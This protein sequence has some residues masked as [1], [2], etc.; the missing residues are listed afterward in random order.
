MNKGEYIPGLD[1]VRALA[2][3]AVMVFHA[4][5]AGLAP[6]GFLGVDVFFVLS[7]FLI[8]SLLLRERLAT[9]GLRLGAFYAGRL[10]RLLPAMLAMLVV[11]TLAALWWAPDA[12][13]R[14][15]QDLPAALLYVS[16]WW[17][18]HSEQSYFEMFGRPPLLQHLW[19]LAIEE[20]F[21]LA[22]PLLLLAAA[23]LGGR[24]G[25]L[26]VAA[27]LAGCSAGWMALLAM[28]QGVPE[29]VDPNRLYLGTDTHAMGLLMG[30]VLACVWNPWAARV[31]PSAVVE[32]A[33]CPQ[34]TVCLPEPAP[35]QASRKAGRRK[36][37]FRSAV[38][39]TAST[40]H[41]AV[42]TP[43]NKPGAD[44]VIHSAI[45]P[46]HPWLHECLGWAGLAVVLAAVAWASEADAGLYRW[47]FA[48]VSLATC[49][50]IVGATAPRT[51][52]GR[53]LGLPVLRFIGQRS[54]GLYLWHWPVFVLLRPGHE[55]PDDPW[56]AL[57]V[58]LGLTLLL[59]E[60]SYRWVEQ[61]VR[62]YPVR[63]WQRRGWA[64]LAV[65]CA[66]CCAVV[67]QLY[68]AHLP[69]QPQVAAGA[70]QPPATPGLAEL[71]EQPTLLPHMLLSP[72]I[73]QALPPSLPRE[74]LVLTAV[75]DSVLLG[76]QGYLTR[77]LSPIVVE[78]KEGR[79]GSDGFSL[80]RELRTQDRLAD[81]VF[82]HLGTNG[83]LYES[84]LHDILQELSDRRLVVVMNVHA[85]RRW[86]DGNNRM[87]RRV[88]PRYPNA[89]LVDWNALATAHPE[90]LGSDGVHLTGRG[91]HAYV[92]LV[93]EALNPAER[94]SVTAAA[95]GSAG[96]GALRMSPSVSVA[97]KPAATAMPADPVVSAP[98]E[99]E[100]TAARPAPAAPTVPATPTVPADHGPAGEAANAPGH[101]QPER[102]APSY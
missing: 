64:G 47:G 55:M 96:G 75:G 67:V 48:A 36:K 33:T 70:T 56:L 7:G 41:L 98:P 97:T 3:A 53:L 57:P 74:Q 16:N 35:P 66:L 2:V 28:W 73:P 38:Q 20:Q 92:N 93:R 87:L 99:A 30:A 69:A 79:Q 49:L 23:R 29:Q 17:Q 14:Q 44:A 8:T 58:R 65:A 100:P 12:L 34:A 60:M 43:A 22:W 13:R 9:G 101:P 40:Q 102:P 32:T 21:Y 85:P 25:V 26:V 19:S 83:Y 37:K 68:Q 94:A 59:T 76:T 15:Q 6:G 27:V 50:L 61:P 62:A 45:T 86:I 88:I 80:L 11:S 54:Y 63:P 51:L 52:L 72:E 90:Y 31:R 77:N 81:V 46:P 95:A 89:R 78:A 24:Q 91:M 10:R 5:M 18:I 71:G 4:E 82:M 84:G 42:A 39:E 1:G